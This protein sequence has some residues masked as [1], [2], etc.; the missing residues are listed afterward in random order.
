MLKVNICKSSDISLRRLRSRE[1]GVAFEANVG[2]V[3]WRLRQF[4]SEHLGQ[5]YRSSL[6]YVQ[7][8]YFGSDNNNPHK[9][10]HDNAKQLRTC[11]YFRQYESGRVYSLQCNRE[12][13]ELHEQR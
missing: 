1:V 11:I 10:Q 7:K 5:F 13:V 3:F 12:E 9:K 2:E 4:H 6:W 8:D